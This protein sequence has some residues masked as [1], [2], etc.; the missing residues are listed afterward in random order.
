MI[1]I[2][3]ITVSLDMRE[4]Y[5]GAE[6]IPLG[7][8]A[9]G[10]LEMLIRARGA[11]VTKDEIFEHVWS[12]SVVGENNIHVQLSALRKVFGEDKQA[13]RTIPGRGY[14]LTLAIE[15]DESVEVPASAPIARIEA[16]R[17]YSL[18]AMHGP[19][20]GRDS[21]T[22]ELAQALT[23]GPI[24][25]L[26]GPGGIGKT[27]LG[28][29]VA[30]SIADAAGMEV[31]FVPL[32]SAARAQSIVS[33]MAEALGIAAGNGDAPELKDLAAAVHG[34][35]LLVLLDSCEHVIES[36]ATVCDVLV[37]A[38]ADVR[39]LA[40][41][42]EPLRTRGEITHWVDPM[43]TPAVDAGLH[44]ILTCSSVKLFLA[45]LSAFNAA[46]ISDRCSLEMIATICRRLD[47]VPLAIEL[48][49]ARAAVFGIGRIIFELDDRFQFLTGGR[50]TAPRRQQTLEASL[51]WG[52]ELLSDFEKLVLQRLSV[53]SA[54]FSLE[55]ACAV[56]AF[57]Q[58]SCNE[59]TEAIVG[60][61]SKSFVSTT[62]G[63]NTKEYFLLESTR[64]YALRK[65]YGSREAN[66]A[67]SRKAAFLAKSEAAPE[68]DLGMVARRSL[69]AVE[70]V[71]SW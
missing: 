67:L 50:R 22:A 20:I 52:Y 7:A 47:G 28:I 35:K 21:T 55:A 30:R 44:A 38:S 3:R 71:A 9:F 11:T 58:L 66:E 56:A 61:A 10:I 62:G 23:T 63:S 34:R 31:C 40:T 6:L 70:A 36:A 1:K 25:T 27:Q 39:I 65:L 19:L 60:L 41:S 51:D 59:V 26:V 4:V 14:R 17:L 48:A 45:Q 29:A 68:H 24:V 69:I 16:G 37:Q 32:A 57:G 46:A 18:P 2:G 53:F 12:K 49:A 8:R 43:E 5:L 13:I 15:T 54:R 42:R 64:E 33:M